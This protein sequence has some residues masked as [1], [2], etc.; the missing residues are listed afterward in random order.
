MTTQ[1]QR[2]L[3]ELRQEAVRRLPSL[4][5]RLTVKGLD[6]PVR[7]VRDRHGVPHARVTSTHDMW[8]AQGFIHA[9]ER[10]WGME[11]TRRFFQGT[12]SEI[13]GEGGLEVDRLYRRVGVMRAARR[14]WPHV[15]KAGREVVEAYVAGVNAYLDMGFPLPI[16]FEILG[17]TPAQWEPTDVTGRWKLICYSQ[18]TNGQVKLG[19]WQLLK[20][21][22]P[23]LFV[24]LFPYYPEDAPSQVPSAQP[25]GERPLAE[26]LKLFEAAHTQSGLLEENGSNSWAVDGTLTPTGKP[27]LAS[28]PHLAIAVPS[29]WHVHHVEGPEFSFI[30]AS[31]PGVP[32]VTY[33]GH[34]SQVAWGITTAGADAQDL[35]FEQI[36]DGNPPRYLF[37]GEWRE[38]EVHVEEITVKGKPQPVIEQVLET[39]HG[40]VVSGGP[41]SKGP[42]VALSWMGSEVQQTF[43]S[44]VGIHSARSVPEMVEAH[45][46]FTS[47][48]NRIFVDQAGNLGYLLS[49]QIPLRGGGPAH[50]PV[51]GWSGD[52]E[53]E[54]QVPFDEMPRVLNP[55]HHFLN[56]SNNLIV[57]YEF[58]HYVAPAGSPYRA[59][60]VAQ[61]LREQKS[62]TAATFAKMHGDYH[63][64][65]G[66]RLAQRARSAR[67]ATE[68]GRQAQEVLAN[69]DGNHNRDSAGGAAYEVLLWK[70][71]DATL[72]RLRQWMPDPKPGE[73]AF[74]SH[75]E[76]LV[77]L[78]L[79]DDR[80]LLAHE[81]FP[82]DNWDAPLAEALD[83]AAAHLSQELGPDTSKWKWGAL[84]QIAF[85]HGIGRQEPVA[86][87][88][89]PGTFPAGGSGATVNAASHGGGRSF[90]ANSIPTYRQILDLADW[91]QSQF[92]IPPGQSGHVASPHYA[93]LLEEYLNVRYR[94]LLWSW[95]RIQEQAESEQTLEPRP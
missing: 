28:D 65:P 62:I 43:S 90:A 42:A 23:E 12:L 80:A 73:E 13:I 19:R 24:K 1:T 16:E 9:Q 88:L 68:L 69:W 89:N 85:R 44:F 45:R 66:L 82:F 54:G 94:P 47:H 53:W 63:N 46:Q 86:S 27:L 72:G 22:G 91:D 15:E 75:M 39:H 25:A 50:L 2:S 60:R 8:F 7:V 34:N 31:M 5:G 17:Y 87:L 58:P 33:Y 84:H 70:L 71:Y 14:E 81:A 40:P 35:F 95:Q 21:L 26:L 67:P 37:R 56:S 83:A 93:D 51:P 20:V 41:A 55:S 52:H 4:D 79:K 6:G 77:G 32:G 57:S 30:G 38:A 76:G 92:I 49:G 18:S 61:M 36:E 74:R 10:L 64:I 78:I 11:R 3:E 29:F 48:N 59:Q